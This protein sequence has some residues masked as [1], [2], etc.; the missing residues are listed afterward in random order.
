MTLKC[1]VFIAAS[2][3]G[4]IARRNG[5][6]SWLTDP[7][8][9]LSNED[10]GYKAFWDSIDILVMGWKTYAAALT[11][12]EWP[13]T[14]KR[15]VVLS[16]GSPHIPERLAGL[17]D[18]MTGEPGELAEQ[19]E[20][21][22]ARHLYIDGGK[23]IQGFLKARLIEEMTITTIPILLGEGI[24]LFDA[25]DQDIHLTLL[26]SHDYP[27]GFVQNKYRLINP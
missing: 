22:G 23:T 19:L 12:P 3:N 14:G 27:N 2:L 16:H 5:D 15:V 9:Q 25:L 24:P 4:F 10:F 17:V 7:S 1:S 11:F 20:K 21:S 6:I 8:F 18:V 13:Y 26:D